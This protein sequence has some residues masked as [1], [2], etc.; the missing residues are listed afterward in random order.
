MAKDT[1]RKIVAHIGVHEDALYDMDYFSRNPNDLSKRFDLN[2]DTTTI[3]S[4]YGALL[5]FDIPLTDKGNL[6]SAKAVNVINAPYF[7]MGKTSQKDWLNTIRNYPA[8]WA[9]LATDK[10][11]LTVPSD[12]IR[13][14]N[15]PE[16]LMKFWNEVMHADADLA[17]APRKRNHPERIIADNQVAAG[18][19][20][21]TYNKIVVPI[22]ECLSWMLNEKN[23]RA[24]GSW[25]HFHELGHRHQFW[26]IDFDELEEVSVNLYSV[27]V[28]NT[29]L[30]KGIFN[31]V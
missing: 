12:S 31:N 30:H 28:C 1:S 11:I 13:N 19:M 15:D 17:I 8:P 20:F 27:Y 18:Y 10:L 2:K 29:V 6:F 23:K 24:S 21:T 26:G 4:P 7:K 9:E 3:Y 5:Y 22:D 14:L 25:G 16:K